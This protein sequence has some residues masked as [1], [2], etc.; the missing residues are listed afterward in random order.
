MIN[1]IVAVR[2][3]KVGFLSP[4]VDTN[5]ESAKRN[6]VHAIMQPGSLYNTH[7]ADFA[8]YHVA[9]FDSDT[10]EVIPLDRQLI[11]DGTM[12]EV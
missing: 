1:P 12:I 3:E 6:F 2:D 5:L 7:K 4:M 8:L 10:G 9:N 11:I